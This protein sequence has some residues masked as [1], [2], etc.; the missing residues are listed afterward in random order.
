MR[1]EDDDD[2]EF[3]DISSSLIRV[4][5]C[6]RRTQDLKEAIEDG[7]E[8]AEHLVSVEGLEFLLGDLTFWFG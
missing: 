6:Q 4:L 2:D 1:E 7:S 8:Q 3:M 5:S